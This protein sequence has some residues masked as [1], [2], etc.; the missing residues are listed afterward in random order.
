M[1]SIWGNNIKLSIFGESHGPAIGINIDGLPPGIKLDLDDIRFEM[2]RRAPGK[3][4][5]TTSRK[6]DDEFEILSGY[7]NKKTTGT[8]LCIMIKNSDK[9][10]KDYDKIKDLA[11]PGHAD[12]TGYI[13]YDG[14]NDYRGGGHFSGR[15]TA[16]LVFA[17]A[18]AKQILKVKNI[19]IGSHIQSIG[20]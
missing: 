6:E 4:K 3:D 16:P 13:K 19:Y 20:N 17:G 1:S 15:L 5:T 8:P 9:K 12:Y 11:R 10:S 7:F 14:H 18:I 2:S